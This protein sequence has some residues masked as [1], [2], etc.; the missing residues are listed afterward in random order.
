MK[1]LILSVAVLLSPSLLA[2]EGERLIK[3]QSED[4]VT[5]TADLYMIH[6]DTA[7]FIVLFHQAN[8]SRGEYNEIAPELNTLGYN[9]LSVDLR[10]GGAINNVTN[11]T[12]LN[13]AKAMKSTQYVDALVDMRAA[14]NYAKKNFASDKLI[15]WGSSYSSALALK[16]AADMNESV[17]A[18]IAFSPGEYF[19]AQG[20][21]RDYITSV[22]G[23]IDQHTF[24]A[25]AK[26][27]KGNWWGIY[28]SITSDN[29]SYYLPETVGNHGSKALWSQYSDS[30]GYWKALKSFLASI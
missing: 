30:G 11:Q 21:P 22:A 20:K 18:V 3:F 25:S 7:P 29:K 6:P 27:E 23:N 24:I 9:C 2:Q 19:V 8:W 15:I 14:I 1:L 16:L 13:A 4:G 26:S 17:D 28:V 12:K 10:S 5:I